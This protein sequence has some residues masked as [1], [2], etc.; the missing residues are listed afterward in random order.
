[1]SRKPNPFLLRCDVSACCDPGPTP[2]G[3]INNHPVQGVKKDTNSWA[4]ITGFEQV[5]LLLV[6]YNA[7]RWHE[8]GQIVGSH[9]ETR[10]PASPPSKRSDEPWVATIE[11]QLIKKNLPSWFADRSPCGRWSAYWKIW[12]KVCPMKTRAEFPIATVDYKRVS[13][14]VWKWTPTSSAWLAWSSFPP[15]GKDPEQSTLSVTK[16]AIAARAAVNCSWQD[17]DMMAIWNYQH[18]RNHRG[19]SWSLSMPLIKINP[20]SYQGLPSSGLLC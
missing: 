3:R 5:F 4:N 2:G 6:M 12:K 1:M 11:V 8:H 18:H 13:M 7:I 16:S 14:S 19:I 9:F 20:F 10:Q 17:V 15:P